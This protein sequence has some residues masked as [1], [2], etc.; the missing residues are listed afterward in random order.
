MEIIR[1]RQNE[2]IKHFHALAGGGE[3]RRT[4]GEFICAGEKLLQEAL[5]NGAEV[6]MLLWTSPR[7]GLPCRVVTKEIL[8][9]VSPLKNSDGPVF[10]VRMKDHRGKSARSAIVLENVQDPGNVGT[11]LRT[12][13]ALGIDR[14]VLCGACADPWSPKAVR[15]TMGAIFRQDVRRA[16]LEGLREA[17][18]GL[19]LY[20]A[21]LSDSARDIRRLGGKG[22]AFAIGNEGKG[23]SEELLALCDGHVII[24]MESCAESLNA[25]VAAA[26]CMW[27][28]R[29]TWQD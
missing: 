14:V 7:E 12:A 20:G 22:A 4:A 28:M 5:D 19:P 16:S 25:A 2:T 3:A 27:E 10:T 6:T 11:V 1:S 29:R 9:Y 15:A 18:D 17:L 13:D 24:P 21:A 23:L 8:D 26:I